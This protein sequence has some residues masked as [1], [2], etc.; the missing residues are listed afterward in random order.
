MF[1]LKIIACARKKGKLNVNTIILNSVVS[2]SPK[3]NKINRKAAFLN[4][5]SELLILCLLKFKS[6]PFIRHLERKGYK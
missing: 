5:Y 6:N 2:V 4:T 3:H 1:S